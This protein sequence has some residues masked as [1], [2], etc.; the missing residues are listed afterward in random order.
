[1]GSLLRFCSCTEYVVRLLLV[2]FVAVW[3]VGGVL[4]VDGDRYYACFDYFVAE[5]DECYA[6]P[7]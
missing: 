5:D 1:M 2:S 4:M 6:L 7:A 3:F